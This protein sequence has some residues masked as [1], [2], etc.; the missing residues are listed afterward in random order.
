MK[1]LSHR[2]F[3]LS[4]KGFHDV[5]PWLFKFKMYRIKFLIINLFFTLILVT[6]IKEGNTSNLLFMKTESVKLVSNLCHF[7]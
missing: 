7:R 3:S 4:Y 6:N 5:T 2:K 1:M